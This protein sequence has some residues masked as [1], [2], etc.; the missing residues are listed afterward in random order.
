MTSDVARSSS[1]SIRRDKTAGDY[2]SWVLI[3]AALLVLYG[4]TLKLLSET[5]WNSTEQS[6]GPVLLG[7]S[8]WL[9]WH[10]RQ[11]LVSLPTPPSASGAYGLL[12]LAL[13]AYTFGKSQGLLLI[14]A[15]SVVPM[16]MAVLALHRGWAGVR[17]MLLPIAMLVFVVP[18]PPDIVAQLTGPLKSGVSAVA[19]S[20]LS[21]AGYPVARTG[22]IL[23]V[24]QYQM[25]VADA[26]AGLTSMFTL[27]AIGLVYMGLRNHPSRARNLTLGL[28]LV[29]VAFAANIVRVLILVLVTYYFGDEAGQGFVHGAAGIVLFMVATVLMVSGRHGVGPVALGAETEGSADMTNALVR[30]RSALALAGALLAAASA[31]A[32]APTR[33][34][35]EELGQLDLQGDV[36]RRFG[37][38]RVENLTVV[39]VVN[40]QQEQLLK[41]LYSQVL[42]RIYVHKD[43]YR[44]ILAIAYGGDQREGLAAH[45]PEACYA[46]QGF[47]IDV[48]RQDSIQL[49]GRE[50]LVNR[51][52]SS[53]ADRRFEPITYWVMVGEIAVRGGLKKK[54]ADF[55]YTS[56]GLI[57]DGLLF[58]ISSIDS[59]PDI[60]FARQTEFIQALVPS[61]SAPVRRRI[62]G[63]T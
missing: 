30:R 14:E 5:T 29:P 9:F 24:G 50:I 42:E 13:I 43:G 21:A 18:L 49:D 54:L 39:S 38:W 63:L 37:D 7:A 46:A 1:R 22:V 11:A 57:P 56:R 10:Q 48:S 6:Y 58:R 32:L 19:A 3:G 45:Y 27:E 33:H 28:L 44:I 55:Y 47:K 2:S 60:A 20:I 59:R 41:E 23:M 61:L 8:L 26:C 36:P 34:L 35:A 15:G 31:H 51:L 17:A 16:T 25:L 53:L 62:S 40:P 4:P 52:E 12:A